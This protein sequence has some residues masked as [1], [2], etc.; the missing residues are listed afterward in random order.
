MSSTPRNYETMMEAVDAL[1]KRGYQY[2]FKFEN[3]ALYCS[4]IDACFAPDDLLITE[5]HRFEGITDPTDSSV[6]YAIESKQGHKGVL[7]D[8]YGVYADE[9]KNNFLKDIPV[10]EQKYE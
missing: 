6:V 1:L 4:G 3:G 5:V 7:I 9:S 8:A 10:K 2:D